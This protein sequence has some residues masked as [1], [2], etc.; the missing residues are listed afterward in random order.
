ME[1]REGKESLGKT[2]KERGYSC[3]EVGR[4]GSLVCQ[5][6]NVNGDLEAIRLRHPLVAHIKLFSIHPSL[7]PEGQ[8]EP[9][10]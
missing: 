4:A 1:C 6:V 10:A 8:R 9:L 3:V 5:V 7:S 2:W